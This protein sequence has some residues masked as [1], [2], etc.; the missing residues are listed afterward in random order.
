MQGVQ[1]SWFVTKLDEDEDNEGD[2]TSEQSMSQAVCWV[3]C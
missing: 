2:D 3:V 1:D